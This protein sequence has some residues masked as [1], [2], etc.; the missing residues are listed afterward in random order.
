MSASSEASI[1]SGL[2]SGLVF[3]TG[4]VKPG[5]ATGALLVPGFSSMNM[6]WSPVRGRASAVASVWIRCLYLS[7]ICIDTYA[8]PFFSVIP[9]I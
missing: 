8:I 6:S 7:S 5:F 9:P 4:I 2:T 1:S 3:D